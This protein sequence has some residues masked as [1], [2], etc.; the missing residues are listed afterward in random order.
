MRAVWSAQHPYIVRELHKKYGDVVRTAPGELSFAN[1][2]AWDDIYSNRAGANSE[3]FRKSEIW[4]GNPGGG[5]SSVFVT[6]DPKKH[7]RIRRFLDPAFSERATLRQEPILREYA[8][9]CITKLRA[10]LFKGSTTINICD[11][12]N[13]FLF[14]TIGD[15]S[16]GESF[17]CLEKCEH[18]PWMTQMAAA[19]KLHYIS[20]N[21]RHYPIITAVLKPFSSYLLPPDLMAQQMDYHKRSTEKLNR[22]LAS[23]TNR[24]DIVSQLLK[25]DDGKDG[26]TPEEIRLNCML[27][28]NAASETT[29]TTLTGAVNSLLQNP[30]S[31]SKLQN[32]IRKFSTTSELTLTALKQLPY[33]DGVL[34]E[35]LRMCNP[36]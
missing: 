4:H 17:D 1:A 14:D 33:L 32:E 24:P 34:N 22:R 27:F 25:S 7:A 26:L 31:M 3:A 23:D 5:P 13:F 29:A 18:E 30:A 15:L 19:I 10:R 16:F 11:W 21:L 20:I 28:I 12:F 6:I 35:A 2:V 36:K 8:D 9:L